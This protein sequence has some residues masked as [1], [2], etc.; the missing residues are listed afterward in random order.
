MKGPRYA[1]KNRTRKGL[2][3]ISLS[4]IFSLWCLVFIFYSRLGHGNRESYIDGGSDNHMNEILLQSNCSLNG[5]K[6]KV[7][8]HNT[9][10]S[11]Y[12]VREESGLKEV[13]GDVLRKYSN[14]ECNVQSQEEQNISK[15][16]EK[17]KNEKSSRSPYLGLDEFRNKTKQGKGR[18]MQGQVGNITHRLEPGGSEYNYA[19][20]SKGAKVLAHNKEAKGASNILGR[21]KDKYLR[22][23][24]SAEE[25]FVA[26]ELSEETLVDAVQIAN[27]EHYSSNFKDFVL[28]GSLTYPTEAWISLGN[29][30]AGNVKHAQKFMLPEPKWVRYLRIN[31]L[32]HYGSEFYCTLSFV[33]VYGVDAIERMLEDMIVVSDEPAVDQSLNSKPV[34][35]LT[36]GTKAGSSGKNEN[37]NVHSKVDPAVKR[38]DNVDM[39]KPNM[40]NTKTEVPLTDVP[41]PVEEVRQ[42]PS[43]RIPGDTVLK[44]LMQKVRSLELNLSVLE[45]YIKEVSRRN[46]DILPDLDKELSRHM[47]LLEKTKYEIKELI[48]WKE[49]MD[50]GVHELESW[51]SMVSSQMDALVRENSILRSNVEKVLSDQAIMGNKELAVL[52]VNLF[53]ASVAFFKLVL[54]QILKL[55]RI[56]ESEKNCRTC[57]GWLLILMSSSMT[58]VIILLCN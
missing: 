56:C 11:M 27:L 15:L 19:S 41:D 18:D 16:E 49:V 25:K 48:E 57:R 51:K 55:F 5:N 46:S 34:V 42:Q 13:M 54:D 47:L 36:P 22:N 24:C 31:L 32:T 52:T 17:D 45:E 8:D 20:A 33:E 35:V 23:P 38:A 58:T 3:E 21:D 40:P 2:Y 14:L 39:Q 44:I 4:L 7:L 12:S 9:A 28:L 37:D 10:N 50:K 6:S 29:F 53:F 1:S 30:V 26:I 43:G